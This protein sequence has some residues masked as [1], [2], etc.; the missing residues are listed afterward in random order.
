MSLAVVRAYCSLKG[1]CER[2]AEFDWS[3]NDDDAAKTIEAMRTALADV[4]EA[5]RVMAKEREAG[6]EILM[7]F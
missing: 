7:F 5:E 3:D 4:H 2:I 6:R 1:A